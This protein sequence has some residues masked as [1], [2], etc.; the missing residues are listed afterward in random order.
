MGAPASNT[1]AVP[2]ADPVDVDNLMRSSVELCASA[3]IRANSNE[4]FDSKAWKDLLS[5]HENR[6]TK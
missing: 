6:K 2:K 1:N 4:T 5:R 3:I